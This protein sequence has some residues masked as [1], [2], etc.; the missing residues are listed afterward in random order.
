MTPDEQEVVLNKDVPEGGRVVAHCVPTRA[1]RVVAL[2]GEKTFR[3]EQLDAGIWE[4]KAVSTHTGDEEFES[5]GPALQDAITK[6]EE[7][8]K[9][10]IKAR[11]DHKNAVAAAEREHG[12]LTSH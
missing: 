5:F 6:Q 1:F 8:K 10:I 3:V 11:I 7:F 4:W 2:A 12:N 9:R